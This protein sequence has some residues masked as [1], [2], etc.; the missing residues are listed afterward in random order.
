MSKTF[1]CLHC[2]QWYPKNPCLKTNQS[3]CGM[4]KCQQVRK[5]TW[6]RKKLQNDAT[7]KAK[8]QADKKKWYSKYPGDKY[9]SEYRNS[10]P[11]YCKDNRE[12]QVSHNQKRKILTTP[13]TIVK[14]DALSPES[15]APQGLY[16]LFPYK[17][18]DAKKIVKTD[19]LIVQI[20]AA[21][22][23]GNNF[24]QNSS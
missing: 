3:Y 12:K 10:H 15:V 17:K 11:E 21:S 4:K 19:A 2:H 1:K 24:L 18:P 13:P 14:T 9:Q 5:N 22:E 8:R 20:V 23:L 16:I 6:E 7:Y